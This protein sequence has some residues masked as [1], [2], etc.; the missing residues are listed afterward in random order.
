[1]ITPPERWLLDTN[2]WV[3]GLRRHHAAPECAE[4]LE[5]IGAFSVVIPLQVL[6]ELSLN[7]TADET[8]QFY[9]LINQQSEWLE[10]SWA[11]A[12]AD[13]V[14]FYQQRGCRKGDAVIAAHAESFSAKTIVSENRQFLRAMK[15][16]PIRILTAADALAR[17]CEI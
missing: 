6:K 1:M 11:K 8:N 5:R 2:I 13:R 14:E 12:T 16:L 10:L 15:N 7:L 4:L 3:F 17:L 9:S